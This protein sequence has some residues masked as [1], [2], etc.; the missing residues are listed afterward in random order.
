MRRRVLMDDEGGGQRHAAGRAAPERIDIRYQVSRA[1]VVERDVVEPGSVQQAAELH[2]IAEA[3]GRMRFR[4]IGRRRGADLGHGFADQPLN[5]LPVRSIPPREGD[6]AAR[7]ERAQALGDGGFRIGK[8]ADA[9]GAGDRLHGA[10]GQRQAL[11]LADAEIDAGMQPPR[12]LQH[13][14]REVDAD[15]PRTPSRRLGC[16]RA[17]AGRHIQEP[18]ARTNPQRLEQGHNGPRRHRCEKA[19]I[20]LGQG[21][22]APALVG[23]QLRGIIGR[24]GRGHPVPS[25]SFGRGRSCYGMRGAPAEGCRSGA[26]LVHDVK[27]QALLPAGQCAL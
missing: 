12:N 13:A 23:T 20:A 9:E 21:V 5:A 19:G 17:G 2:R 27:E 3:Q 26:G 1:V 24:Q 6:A 16:E 10:I 11:D 8:V 18:S 14:R 7:R 15:D 4:H 22:V 25:R